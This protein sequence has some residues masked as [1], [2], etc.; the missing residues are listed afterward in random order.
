MKTIFITGG[1]T[2]IGA[3]TAK[4]FNQ[5]NWRIII[6]SRNNK[7]LKQTKKSILDDSTNKEV[8]SI[9]CD[10]SKRDE[11]HKAVID[12][13][14]NIAPID[15]ALLNAAAYSPNKSQ[16][17]DIQNYNLL[18]DVNLKG[19]LNCIEILQKQMGQERKDISQ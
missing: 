15:L 9:P 7:I 11:I 8:Y 14:K 1:S 10:I 13:E 6:S 12:I 16:Q 2:G 17:F 3:A 4:K 18:I 19:T 5:N